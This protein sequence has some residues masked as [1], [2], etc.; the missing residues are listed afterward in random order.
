MKT[1]AQLLKDY[2]IENFNERSISRNKDKVVVK[3]EY[4]ISIIPA[5]MFDK[6]ILSYVELEEKFFYFEARVDG[7]IFDNDFDYEAFTMIKI[8]DFTSAN[9]YFKR[10]I[11]EAE[12]MFDEDMG[13]VEIGF[14]EGVKDFISQFEKDFLNYKL[15]QTLKINKQTMK[16]V[17]I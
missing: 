8:D 3:D 1:D 2:L 7:N 6:C 14:I 4:G 16:S 9:K 15:G 11:K 13:M 17:K 12:D 5:D 10:I